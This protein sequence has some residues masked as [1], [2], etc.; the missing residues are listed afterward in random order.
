[1]DKRDNLAPISRREFYAALALVWTFIMLAFAATIFGSFRW[2]TTL[3]YLAGSFLM[4]I[5]Y[6]VA[7]WRGEQPRRAIVLAV[8]LA[9]VALAVGAGAYLSG[10][11]SH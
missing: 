4:V 1:M 5:S 7:S 11:I 2:P 8:F 9:T 6:S 10:R 3:I